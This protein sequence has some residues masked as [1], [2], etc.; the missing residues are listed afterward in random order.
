MITIDHLFYWFLDIQHDPSLST[1][2]Q[3]LVA[4]ILHNNLLGCPR[5]LGSMV[6]KWVISPPYKCGILGL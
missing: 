3:F 5:K 1:V 6:S 4:G 2:K